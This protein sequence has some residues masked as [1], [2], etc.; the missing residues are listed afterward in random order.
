[1]RDYQKSWPEVH[2]FQCVMDQRWRTS[3]LHPF[4]ILA[5]YVLKIRL[6]KCEPSFLQPVVKAAIC[7]L[8]PQSWLI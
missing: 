6:E 5:Y 7:P 2:H 1:M 4:F 8:D 3:Y